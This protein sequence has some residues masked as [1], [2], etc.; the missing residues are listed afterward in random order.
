MIMI[1]C[2]IMFI[3]R[4]LRGYLPAIWP[5]RRMV[6]AS[7]HPAS[8]SLSDSDMC[9]QG[10]DN[11]SVAEPIVLQKH[12]K[13][14]HLSAHLLAMISHSADPLSLAGFAYARRVGALYRPSFDAPP[15]PSPETGASLVF[16]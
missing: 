9:R 5:G 8:L 12:E 1:K 11:N 7:N 6:M 3:A 15:T 10:T 13:G 4:I 14:G 2:S 16:A